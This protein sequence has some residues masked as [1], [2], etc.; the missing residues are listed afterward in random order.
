MTF[1][2]NPVMRGGNGCASIYRIIAISFELRAAVAI[3]ESLRMIGARSS[4]VQPV[5]VTCVSAVTR[6]LT[7]V[8]AMSL[9][10]IDGV[11]ISQLKVFRFTRKRM[12]K[13]VLVVEKVHA[14]N[15]FE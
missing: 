7:T 6:L 1:A 5:G 4:S 14:D 2:R 9:G 10:F 11:Y 8:V 13:M 15:K 12:S 3:Y